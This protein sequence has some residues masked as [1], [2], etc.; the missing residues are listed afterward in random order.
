MGHQHHF[1]SRLDRVS[2]PHV[3]LALT[4]YRDHGLVQYLLRCARLPDGA[5]RVAISLDDP[6]RGPFLVVTR[7]GRFVTCLGAGMRAG[8][9][10]VITRGQLD[11]LT[12]KVA[13]L[14][15]RMAAARELAGPKGHTAQLV[16]RIFHAGPDLSREEFVGIS[17]FRPLF[18]LASSSASSMPAG[19]RRTRCGCSRRSASTI[20]RRSRRPDRKDRPARALARAG[21][22]RS[23]SGAAG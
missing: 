4:L 15:A 5:E 20:T 14:R 13:D 21:A 6:A 2:L 3:E 18:G 1:L 16:D 8:D 12:E 11:G 23:T 19:R 10:P 9:L 7:E 17:A 22:A